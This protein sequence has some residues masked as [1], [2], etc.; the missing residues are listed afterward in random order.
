MLVPAND[1][2]VDTYFDIEDNGEDFPD[3]FFTNLWYQYIYVK[4]FQ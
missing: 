3:Y 1:Y 4:I 2:Y